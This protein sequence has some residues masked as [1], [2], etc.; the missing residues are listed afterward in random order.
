MTKTSNRHV[1][2]LILD[3][4]MSNPNGDP[5]M[6]SEPRT[7]ELDG[8]GMISPVSLKRKFR[9]LVSEN[10]EVFS[11]A[12]EYLKLGDAKTNQYRDYFWGG[13]DAYRIKLSEGKD[14]T[15]NP[16]QHGAQVN[17]LMYPFAQIGTTTLDWLDPATFKY[18]ITYEKH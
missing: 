10:S 11:T 14:L 17:Y 2:L 13:L 16:P 6:E 1:G 7:R 9:D 3:V 4:S 18:T 12:T 8:V 5:D 15:L